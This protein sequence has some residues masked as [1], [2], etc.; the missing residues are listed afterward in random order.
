MLSIS[1]IVKY[2]NN[3]VESLHNLFKS[4]KNFVKVLNL[5][6]FF[7]K[8][9]FRYIKNIFKFYAKNTDF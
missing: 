2:F 1:N 6:L 7:K 9:C 3:L 4:Y 5:I 8:V